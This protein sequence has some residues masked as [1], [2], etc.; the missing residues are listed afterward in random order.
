[1][2][3][4][5]R[6]LFGLYWLEIIILVLF[7]VI[8]FI[9]EQK[10]NF[11]KPREWFFAFNTLIFTRSFSALAYAVP[12]LDMIN[13]HIPLLKDDHPLILRLFMPNF[14]ADSIDVIQQIPFLTFIYLSIGYGFFIRYKIP[15]DRFVRYNI[16]Y[17]IML[18]SLQ[19][20][21]NEMFLAFT[22]TFIVDD[23]LRAQVTLMA[24]FCW[25][26]LYIPCF[27]RAFL[28]KYD[29]NQFIREAVE[30]HL[31]RDGPDFIWWDRERKDKAPKKPPLN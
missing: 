2:K 12:Y 23:Y 15:G 9:L 11:K 3:E 21:L 26:S 20:I 13:L 14:V 27:V 4:A 30:V 17:S 7:L 22:D 29:K 1:M 24:F 18:V 5:I 6:V 10:F 31:G 25:L 8:A 19:G 16:M 28:G